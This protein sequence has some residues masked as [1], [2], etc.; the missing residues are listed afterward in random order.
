MHCLKR[1]QVLPWVEEPQAAHGCQAHTLTGDD[2]NQQISLIAVVHLYSVAHH[3]HTLQT[4]GQDQ[5]M[6]NG[7]SCAEE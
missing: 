2:S 5:V 4:V 6:M 1:G 7:N 3:E